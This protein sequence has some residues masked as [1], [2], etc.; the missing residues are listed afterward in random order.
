MD[1]KRPKTL[2]GRIH[3]IPIVARLFH[4]LLVG[5]HDQGILPGKAQGVKDKGN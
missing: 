5:S 3:D 2:P 1:G 4:L